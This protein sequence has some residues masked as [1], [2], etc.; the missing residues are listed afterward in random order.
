M[1]LK[2]LSA[3]CAAE[4]QEALHAAQVI[5]RIHTTQ[6]VV[7]RLIHSLLICI[8]RH[9]PQA[10][11]YPLLVACKSQSSFRRSAAMHVVDN[12]RQHSATLVEQAQLV[13]MGLFKQVPV[14]TH[15]TISFFEAC[16]GG[17]LDN[18]MLV[19]WQ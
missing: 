17:M 6:A 9:H 11:M 15:L 10:L 8:G 5:A 19:H 2:L 16:Q 14:V 12:V 3:S 18:T 13:R 4:K 1:L 7:R